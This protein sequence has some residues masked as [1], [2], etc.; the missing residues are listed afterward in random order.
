MSVATE[1]FK[2]EVATE[3]I[4][5]GKFLENIGGKNLSSVMAYDYDKHDPEK[6]GEYHSWGLDSGLGNAIF[7]IP[8]GTEYKYDPFQDIFVSSK[9]MFVKF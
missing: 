5:V 9:I 1:N 6:E 8:A 3:D 7:K 2:T 4:L